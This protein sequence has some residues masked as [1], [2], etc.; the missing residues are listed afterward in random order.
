MSRPRRPR[1]RFIESAESAT[2]CSSRRTNWGMT[3]TPSKNPV[4]ATSAIRPSIITL[5]SR[6]LKDFLADFSP[7]NTPPRAARLSRSP[8][9]APTTRPTYI[10]QSSRTICR[11]WTVGD[12]SGAP[13]L[14]T[15]DIRKAPKMPSTEP[16]AA[17]IS[18]FRLIFCTRI[19]KKM[20]I[21]PRASPPPTATARCT[22][23]GCNRYAQTASKR[24]NAL[25][26]MMRSATSHLRRIRPVSNPGGRNRLTYQPWRRFRRPCPDRAT[27]Q[28]FAHLV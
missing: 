13:R 5:V 11:K 28:P 26:M 14:I 8:L 18:R 15:S 7:P 16:N 4:S 27:A 3:R 19:S 9:L 6:I 20:M 25:R 2:N 23:N 24:M 17:P 1:L 22:P 12:A 10:I 21:R